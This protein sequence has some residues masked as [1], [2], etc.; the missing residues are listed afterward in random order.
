MYFY[1]EYD[2]LIEVNDDP[3]F[4]HTLSS[5][6]LWAV[7]MGRKLS[8]SRRVKNYERKKQALKK[9]PPGR[10]RKVQAPPQTQ[11]QLQQQQPQVNQQVSKE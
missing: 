6:Q 5:V 9:R 7:T 3:K 2:G 8:L 10:P 11:P 4:T 1:L